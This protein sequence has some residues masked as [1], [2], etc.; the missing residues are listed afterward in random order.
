MGLYLLYLHPDSEWHSPNAMRS[1]GFIQSFGFI[2]NLS[3]F[4]FDT[5]NIKE[6]V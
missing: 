3:R 2:G 6:V 1:L 4:G 5:Y